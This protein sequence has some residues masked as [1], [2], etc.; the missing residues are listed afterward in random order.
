[1][2]MAA[3]NSGD[4][5]DLA[6]E[7][8]LGLLD[9]E[10]RARFETLLDTEPAARAAVARQRDQLLE[11]DLAA[12]AEVPSA[13]LWPAIETQLQAPDTTVASLSA[14]RR[15]RTASSAA[16]ATASF[17]RGFAAAAIVAMIGSALAWTY[18]TPAAP[19]LI[20]VLLDDEA[21][22]VSIVEAFGDE[23]IRVVPLGTIDVPAGKTLEVWTLPDKTTGPVSMGL[24]ESVSASVLTGPA[25]P[26]PKPEQLYEITLEPAGGSPTGRPTGPI[27][28][29]GFAKVPQ[30]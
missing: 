27:I 26:E 18:V 7:Y 15:M 4:F 10:A 6:G 3:G 5:E 22:P 14:H 23:R 24:L 25:L 20:V 1:M 11:I 29:K 2:T 30:I 17:W 28:G 21:K 16:S 9:D 13:G 19:R 8:V 12:P